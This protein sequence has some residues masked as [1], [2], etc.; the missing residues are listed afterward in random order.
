M[1]VSEIQMTKFQLRQLFEEFN[2]KLNADGINAKYSWFMYKNC[3]Q[4][5]PLYNELLAQLYDERREP[6]YPAWFQEHQSLIAEFSD[7]DENGK[8]KQDEH[9]LPVITEKAEEFKAAFASF[10][11]K[12]KDFYEKLAKKDST[13]REIYMQPVSFNATQLEI[14]EFPP[15]TKPYVVGLL[16]Y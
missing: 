16:G 7:K 14:S 4:M 10:K 11:E 8:A 15:N 2:P 9:G 5:V 6:E 12:Y 3:E 1:K 13:N